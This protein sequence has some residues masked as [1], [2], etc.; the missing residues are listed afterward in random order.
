MTALGVLAGA[1]L[2]PVLGVE[3]ARTR[4]RDVFVV[5]AGPEANGL[6]PEDVEQKRIPIWQYGA[7]VDAFLRR[8]VKDVYLLGKWTARLLADALWDDAARAVLAGVAHKG[9]HEVI[10]AFVEDMTRRGLGIRSQ[11]ELLKPLLVPADFAV[12]ADALTPQQRRDIRFGYDV[13]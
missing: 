5:D 9:E 12:G 8:G 1:G 3:G 2:M 7:V 6:L 10:R 4:G 11:V 13:A